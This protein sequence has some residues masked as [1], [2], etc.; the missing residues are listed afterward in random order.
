MTEPGAN[1]FGSRARKR[2][3]WMWVNF[4][5]ARSGRGYFG[6]IATHLATCGYP[7]YKGRLELA[8]IQPKG[9]LAA[10]AEISH[11]N[12]IMGNNVFIGDRVIIYQHEGGGS[13]DLGDRVM[14]FDET[15][16]ETFAGGSLRVGRDTAIQPRCHFTAAVAPIR[17]GNG[18]QIAPQCAFYSYDHGIAPD[19]LI[20]N[21]SLRSKGPIII[22]DDAWLGFGVIVLSGVHIGKGAVIGAGAVVTR[23]VPEGA[24]AAGSPAHVVKMR[25]ELSEVEQPRFLGAGR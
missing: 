19:E 21:Q 20:R 16:V 11:A 1:G 23:D 9:Y 14:L 18:V 10:S 6:R 7:P 25:S 12:L 22:E 5:L 24:V 3:A 15:I 4:W 2:M 17:I 8:R 13:V